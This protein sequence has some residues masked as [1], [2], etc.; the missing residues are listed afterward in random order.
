VDRAGQADRSDASYTV[1][2]TDFLL[3]GG[4]ANLSYLTRANPQVHDVRDCATFGAR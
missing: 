4:E 3:T 1:A 2:M